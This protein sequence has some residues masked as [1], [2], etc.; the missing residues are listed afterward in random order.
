MKQNNQNWQQKLTPE[1]YEVC[2]LRGTEAPFSGDLLDNK[3]PGTY[4]CVACGTALFSSENKFNS[5][6]GWPSFN[7]A[8]V[9]ENVRLEQ[10]D[11]H[12][13]SRVEVRCSQCDSHLGH[14]FSDGPPPTG[15]RFCINS[16]ALKFEPKK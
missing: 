6:T 15:Q 7:D 14:V 3:E 1:Q 10:D 8:M 16:V 5:G 13:M 2:R 11:S 12:G 9:K 4:H